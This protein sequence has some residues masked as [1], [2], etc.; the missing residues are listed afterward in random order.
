MTDD[1][2]KAIEITCDANDSE[3][4]I[5][6]CADMTPVAR[7]LVAEVRRLTAERD[8][9]WA[10]FCERS[11]DFKKRHAAE[12]ALD[13]A[14]KALADA[15]AFRAGLTERTAKADAYDR[16]CS[17]LGI[18][19][20]ALGFI[21]AAQAREQALRGALAEVGEAYKIAATTDRFFDHYRPIY[22]RIRSAT[23]TLERHR[24]DDSALRE[25]GRRL[26]LAVYDAAP[27]RSGL[28]AIVDAVLRG[29][30]P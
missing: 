21:A 9:H 16:I 3:P 10:N 4:Y 15:N 22:D 12:T 6:S 1:E 8:A 13:E 20:D 30:K 2:L 14:R 28:S 18:K 19:G 7:T 26:A 23:A 25:F 29:D 5:E 24:A 17:T 27:E 11:G